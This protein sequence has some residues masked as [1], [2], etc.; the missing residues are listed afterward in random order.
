MQVLAEAHG[1]QQAIDL[2]RLHRP[3]ITLMDLRMPGIGGVDATRTICKEFPGSRI[4]V[5][6]SYDGDEDIYRALRAGARAYLLKDTYR[7]DLLEAIRAVHAGERR[8]SS[9]VASRL[10]QRTASDELTAREIEVL[11]LIAFGKTD[12][13]IGAALGIAENT[14]KWH[15]NSVIGKLDASNRT[16]AAT[17]AIRRGII[18]LE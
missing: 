10:A 12:R 17:T 14:A 8:L 11:Q 3:S 13:Q 6:T 1:G 4:I 15:V 5:L 7:E 18:H 16:E 2:F 9:A